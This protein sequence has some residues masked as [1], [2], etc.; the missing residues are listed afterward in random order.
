MIIGGERGEW[1][2]YRQ[3]RVRMGWVLAVRGA[4][5]MNIGGWGENGMRIEVR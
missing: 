2:E 4:N 3:W 1:D 5:E